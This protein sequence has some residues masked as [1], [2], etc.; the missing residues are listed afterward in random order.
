MVF[1]IVQPDRRMDSGDPD[2]GLGQP[3]VRRAGSQ[4]VA[5]HMTYRL[6]WKHLLHGWY[7]FIPQLVAIF[8]VLPI[9]WMAMDRTPPLRLYD[10]AIIPSRVKPLEHNITVMWRADFS[11]RDCGGTTQRELIDSQKNL[12]P[13]QAR[14]RRGV[15]IPA[16][17]G[18]LTGTVMTPPLSIPNMAPG[19]ATYRVTQFYYCNW[20][21]R[22][23]DWPIISESP[24]IYFEV[25]PP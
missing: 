12:W 1:E 25:E 6:K 21:Q 13:K 17:E 24:P 20:I 9:A 16:Y 14:A 15:F 7:Y 22:L 11:G 2:R 19:R 10:G 18:A 5:A 3:R 23:F 4:V 8:I